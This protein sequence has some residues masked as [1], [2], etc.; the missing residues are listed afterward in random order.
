M[1]MRLLVIVCALASLA[2]LLL[3]SAPAWAQGS[4]DVYLT[5]TVGQGSTEPPDRLRPQQLREHRAVG[6]QQQWRLRQRLPHDLGPPAE[7]NEGLA[8]TV[9]PAYPLTSIATSVE[10]S[11]PCSSSD[12]RNYVCTDPDDDSPERPWNAGN[13][14]AIRLTFTPTDESTVVPAP[15]TPHQVPGERGESL[16]VA[17]GARDTGYGWAVPQIA[18]DPDGV[19]VDGGTLYLLDTQDEYVYAFDLFSGFRQ[20][21]LEFDLDPGRTRPL[22]RWRGLTYVA[23][24]RWWVFNG[25]DYYSY[26]INGTGPHRSGGH[27]PQP[28]VDSCGRRR[29][30]CLR[31][32]QRHRKTVGSRTWARAV[33]IR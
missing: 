7:G 16:P 20:Q 1:T 17:Y 12:N 19:H 28:A 9:I 27:R 14:L 33:P 5:V 30:H 29:H 24:N 13:E 10:T 8:L 25:D 15:G 31:P 3:V 11:F 22:P 26:A 23:G 2:C 21:F 32:A 18:Q 6:I 4:T